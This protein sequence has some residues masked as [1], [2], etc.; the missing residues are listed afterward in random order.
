MTTRP[1]YDDFDGAG[2][3]LE[4]ALTAIY[5][6]SKVMAELGVYDEVHSYLGSRLQDHYDTARDA[7]ARIFG[8]G[9]YSPQRAGDAEKGGAA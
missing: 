4:N 8:L 9:E 7:M 3:D 6:L 5:G 2:G 1:K